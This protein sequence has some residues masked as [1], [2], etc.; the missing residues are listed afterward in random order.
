[1]ATSD[2]AAS[3]IQ[4]QPA[5]GWLR[6]QLFLFSAAVA[7]WVPSLGARMDSGDPGGELLVWF[8]LPLLVL[9]AGNAAWRLHVRGRVSAPLAGLGTLAGSALAL[10]IWITPH[11]A[12]EADEAVRVVAGLQLAIGVLLIALQLQQ[13]ETVRTTVKRRLQRGGRQVGAGK[14]RHADACGPTAPLGPVGRA[15]VTAFLNVFSV[16]GLVLNTIVL[17]LLSFLLIGSLGDPASDSAGNTIT[18][19]LLV[20]LAVLELTL[21]RFFRGWAGDA[22][23][24]APP[25]LLL[26]AAVPALV[27]FGSQPAV[28]PIEAA[29]AV[30]LSLA[31]GPWYL[32]VR[33]R[34][35]APVASK[36]H[37]D[38]ISTRG[39]PDIHTPSAAV[40][41]PIGSAAKPWSPSELW[42]AYLVVP[43]LLYA[44]SL[45]LGGLLYLAGAGD[46]VLELGLI[47][48]ELLVLW[49]VLLYLV[50]RKGHPWSVLGIK[51]FPIRSLLLV[52]VA[53][54]AQ[55]AGV[56]MF[57]VAL[58]PLLPA[59]QA[60]Q[61]SVDP[62]VEPS[63]ATI[64][65]LFLGMVVVAPV[66]EELLFRGFFFAGFRSYIGPAGAAILSAGLFSLAHAFPIFFP[67]SV[68]IHPSQA[69]GTFFG[70]LVFAGLR[71]DSDSV[72]P[73]MLAH[74]VWNLWVI[75]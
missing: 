39:R 33:R 9:L 20:T 60:Y 74:A 35:S 25:A 34:M 52:P 56:S 46:A 68:A 72:F 18:A 43:I 65:L 45:L 59:V 70:G 30:T 47:E 62:Y 38:P 17:G 57:N 19:G 12:I 27:V 31:G 69:L 53:S 54:V 66:V 63:S 4:A 75:L 71:H 49:V 37:S 7:T 64:A 61:A 73:S 48:A 55:Y 14:P 40:D 41:E 1:M 11:T 42:I 58:L 2:D 16:I 24:L 36:V 44:L 10:E 5:A 8:G 67:F 15:A 3:P 50:R 21:L 6:L 26:L 23:L 51:P 29:L 28:Y 22:G 13:W 32:K